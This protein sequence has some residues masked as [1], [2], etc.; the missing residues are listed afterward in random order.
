MPISKIQG[1][2][3]M[4]ISEWSTEKISNYHKLS[5]ESYQKV[6]YGFD[7]LY[8]NLSKT[9]V[10]LLLTIILGIT[11]ETFLLLCSFT[12]VR[13]S[14]FGYHSNN[15][16]KC[17]IVG[18]AGFVFFV[19]VAILLNPFNIVVI[20]IIYLACMIVFFSYAPVETMKR[21]IGRTRKKHFKKVTL[22]TSTILFLIAFCVGKN[23]YRNLII[24]GILLEAIM[25]LPIMKKI[26][27]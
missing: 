11:K 10:L 6:K 23:L 4:S 5:E 15:T 26:I 25:I 24:M 16:L 3:E 20:S 2:K 21:P 1:E 8:I 14:G 7:I 9:A 18:I 12:C 22:V 19:Y 13:F 17:T 27:L